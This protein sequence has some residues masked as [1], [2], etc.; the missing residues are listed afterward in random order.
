MTICSLVSGKNGVEF[1]KQIFLTGTWRLKELY[2][3][4]L[5]ADKAVTAHA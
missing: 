3:R 5:P 1:T 2:D 4:M